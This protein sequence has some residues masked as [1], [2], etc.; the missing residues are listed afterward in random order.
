[1]ELMPNL[2]RVVDPEAL[3][4]PA[5]ATSLDFFRAVYRSSAQPMHRRMK[6]ASEAAQYEHP[7]LSVTAQIGPDFAGAMERAFRRSSAVLQPPKMIE[8][9]AVE[10]EDKRT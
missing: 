3:Q 9:R 5:D 6:A 10:V 8:S 7:K 4:I 1:M 2:T